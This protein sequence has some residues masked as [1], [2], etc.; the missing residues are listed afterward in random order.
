MRASVALIGLL[1]LLA[2]CG[3]PGAPSAVSAGSAE[4]AISTPG[5]PVTASPAASSFPEGSA[6]AGVAWTRFPG[7][8]PM[9]Y[10]VLEVPRDYA[11]PSGDQLRLMLGR[12]PAT[13][14]AKRIGSIVFYSP[15]GPEASGIKTLRDSAWALVPPVVREHFD[16]VTFDARGLGSSVPRVDCGPWPENH[17][18]YPRDAE[19]WAAWVAAI[20]AYA[21]ACEATFG[22][23][24]P[25]LGTENVVRDLER[26]RVALGEPRLTYVGRSSG[27]LVGSLYA[28]HYPDRVRAMILDGPEDQS[29]A[30]DS[31]ALRGVT[32]QRQ[33]ERFLAACS[34]DASC[35]FY[36][37]GKARAAFDALMAR[38]AES[39]IGGIDEYEA[40]LAI[41]SELDADSWPRLA[42]MLALARDGRVAAFKMFVP[43]RFG[44]RPVGFLYAAPSTCVDSPFPR[45]VAAFDRA[46]AKA[47]ASA[48]DFAW[49]PYTYLVCAFWPVPSQAVS[50]EVRAAGAPPILVVASTDDP[51][52]PDA[53][54]VALADQLES[55]V[56]V[57]R[58]GAGR[59]SLWR[60]DACVDAI[61][62]AYLLRLEAPAAR[63]VC[64]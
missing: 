15:D 41:R 27:T 22:D 42:E 40:W 3:S 19:A 7:Q 51:G 37:D 29:G 21:S 16:L 5:Q 39:P 30:L 35:A 60:G 33:L 23:L 10:A 25:H 58:E 20:D 2:G 1:A 17:E 44:G 34:S 24:L 31:D 63:T 52:A 55:G 45:D 59:G 14:P 54:A 62:E 8:P 47:R 56:L 53:E 50:T 18:L 36:S 57:T 43:E 48:P 13:D 28:E 6:A 38:F 26:I 12:M 49:V 32:S 46:A 11:D 4:P 64:R 9:E 61:A